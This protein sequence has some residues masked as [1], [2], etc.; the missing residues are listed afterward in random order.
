[1][2]GMFEGRALRALAGAS[3]VAAGL[4]FVAAPTQAHDPAHTDIEGVWMAYAVEPAGRLG[5]LSAKLTDAAKAAVKKAKMNDGGPGAPEP[6]WY[7]VGT[8]MPYMMP[9]LASYPI[10]I[11]QS[12]G[13]TIMVSENENQIRRV[14]TDGRDFPKD[15]PRTR[16]GYSI[17]HWDGK[18]FVVDTKNFKPWP[19][20]GAPRSEAMTITERFTLTSK[21][22]VKARPSGFVADITP[23]DDRVLIDHMTVTDPLFYQEPLNVTVYFEPLD[24]KDTLEY[25]CTVDLWRQAVDAFKKGKDDHEK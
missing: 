6:G 21:D 17:G 25:D 11:V 8:G 13:F 7:C 10:T 16:A 19:M 14:Y 2:R 15:Y 20:G 9:S 22:K 1:M 23:K 5:A 3:I 24:D 18:T 4:G 12:P